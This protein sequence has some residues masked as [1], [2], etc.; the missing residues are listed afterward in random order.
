M[1]NLV[2]RPPSP[3]PSLDGPAPDS[4]WIDAYLDDKQSEIRS[5]LQIV[6][7]RKWLVLA[8][9]LF[10][11]GAVAVNTYSTD[12]VYTSSVNIQ[13]DP[14]QTILPYKNYA[15][16]IPDPRYLGTQAQVLKSEA[17]AQRAVT[18][19]E[20]AKDDERLIQLARWFAGNVLV[21]PV[22]GTQ[23]VK[24]TYRSDDAEFA[25]RAVNVLADEYITYGFDSKRDASG[26]ARDFLQQELTKVQQTLQQSEQRLVDYGRAHDILMPSRDNNV[27]MRKLTEL[28][29]EMTRIE[30]Q[31]RADQYDVLRHTPLESFR[32]NYG[33][34]SPASSTAGAPTSSRSWRRRR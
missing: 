18:R 22:E 15:A 28:D 32:R 26:M 33:R 14:E 19:L 10:V 30:A 12:R 5:Y 1:A 13:I 23:V 6:V 25:A 7:K 9:A 29:A 16:V 34:R 24:V 3:P 17:L 4:I 20:L 11:F 8:V 2:P 21:A 27:I 31:V